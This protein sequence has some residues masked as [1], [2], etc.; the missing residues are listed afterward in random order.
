MKTLK[1]SLFAAAFMFTG[2]YAAPA[3]AQRMH[4]AR[5]VVQVVIPPP[6]FLATAVPVYYQGRPA[7]WYQNR[8]YYRD[9]R[10]WQYY[11]DEPVYLRDYRVRRAPPPRVYYRPQPQPVYYRPA[12]QPVYQRPQPVHTS[13]PG[14]AYPG[15]RRH[16][17]R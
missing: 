4:R 14:P 8:W 12:P 5:P 16:R 6:S 15:Q 13:R 10:N 11:N 17:Y 2:L 9:G 7:Y 3:E 1:T